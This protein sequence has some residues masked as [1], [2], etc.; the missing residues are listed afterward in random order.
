M[1]YAMKIIVVGTLLGAA[2]LPGLARAE[3]I[4]LWATVEEKSHVKIETCGNLLC[5]TI[6]W[7]KEPNDENGVAK[8][9]R[10]N[11]DESLRDRPIIGLKLLESF[12]QTGEKPNAWEDGSIYNPEDGKTYASKMALQG[13]DVLLVEGCV[14][15]FCKEQTWTRVE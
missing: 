12:K 14:W 7:L 8:R 13:S 11:E 4:G 6:V 10:N 5:G 9:D 15:I 2:L 3:A 1:K